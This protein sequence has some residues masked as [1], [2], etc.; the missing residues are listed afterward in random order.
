MQDAV[1]YLLTRLAEGSTTKALYP[2]ADITAGIDRLL[3]LHNGIPSLNEIDELIW[4]FGY[5]IIQPN[6][7][8][9][10]GSVTE[11][12]IAYLTATS[13][14]IGYNY[15][16][17]NSFAAP[18]DRVERWKEELNIGIL[19]IEALF[20]T[21]YINIEY[22][23]SM[24]AYVITVLDKWKRTR[25]WPHRIRG[26]VYYPIPH[27]EELYQ[28]NR[29]PVIKNWKREDDEIF[30]EFLDESFVAAINK[31]QRQSWKINIPV[32]KE[33]LRN[34]KLYTT[35]PDTDD[36]LLKQQAISKASEFRSIVALVSRI[37]KKREFYQYMECD[38]R[39]RVYCAQPFFNFQGSDFARGLFLFSETK[40]VT[41]KG[42]KWLA[43]HTATCFN[44][45]YTISDIPSWC[46]T[47]YA[48]YLE[49]EGLESISVDKMT[50]GDREE[51]TNRNMD[52]ILKN[53]A[54]KGEKPVSYL[55]CCNE[56]RKY[57]EDPTS[58]ESSLPIPIDGSNNGWQHLAAISQDKEAGRLVGL[59]DEKIQQDF[60]VHTAKEL[61]KLMPQWFED[62]SIP[63]KHIR[64]GIS[65][66]GSM[67]R[68]YSAGAQKIAENMW[69][70]C[71]TEGYDKLY[72]MTKRDCFDL[73]KHLIIAIDRVCTGPLKTMKFLQE[74]AIYK[75]RRDKV[76]FLN[77]ETP[78]G[79][80]VFYEAAT[81]DSEPHRVTLRGFKN[82]KGKNKQ[83]TLRGEFS[84][85]YPDIHRFICGISP[86]FIH[87]LDAAHMCNV[88]DRWDGAFGGVHDSFSTHADDVDN[89]QQ[90]TKEVFIQ[91]YTPLNG[92]NY[93]GIK[94]MLDL[95][96][97]QLQEEPNVG[98]LDL[99]E[100]T[101]SDYFFS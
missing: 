68:A 69:L 26:T 58:F 67:T 71:R 30:E 42:R 3:T 51:W 15:L 23:G 25:V 49:A 53:Y 20:N 91:Q 84:S 39:G 83:I 47:D 99:M 75:V 13:S 19:A 54:V 56:W 77:W 96:D 10:G 93:R 18:E 64:K 98:T 82:K 17:E 4:K 79:F 48:S 41:S 44:Q 57:H 2:N 7:K 34:R 66:R 46:R 72:D 55:A 45:S 59:T 88:I 89:L 8:S 37:R 63:M 36:E 27:I 81:K 65:K 14:R 40:P 95:E 60:Y 5:S 31:L 52:T 38:Y 90:L 76:P 6:S 33:L 22:N 50:M 73:A 1:N 12:G 94:R 21:K 35:V 70:D 92:D 62:R 61:I 28:R 86:N 101:N 87:S 32:Y 97:I 11:P 43:R 74:L 85:N 9:T 78:A 16:N 80:P 29:R 100:V 24:K